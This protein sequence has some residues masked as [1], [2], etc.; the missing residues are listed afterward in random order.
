[1][2]VSRKRP[3]ENETILDF[4]PMILWKPV[5]FVWNSSAKARSSTSIWE[6]IIV[7]SNSICSKVIISHQ[8]DH[9]TDSLWILQNV[10]MKNAALVFFKQKTA[11]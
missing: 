10:E 5:I 11:H 7:F 3:E 8:H 9:G 2:A 6:A 4:K 1:M